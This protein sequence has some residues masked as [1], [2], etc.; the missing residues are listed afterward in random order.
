LVQAIKD[1]IYEGRHND[2]LEKPM[3]VRKVAKMAGWF[4]HEKKTRIRSWGME[5]NG[6]MI[7]LQPS[8]LGEEPG[9]L[10]LK[11][12]RPVDVRRMVNAL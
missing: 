3:T 9:E 4:I 7:C 8:L 10:A 5:T 1:K 2:R 6:Q 11:G 12:V